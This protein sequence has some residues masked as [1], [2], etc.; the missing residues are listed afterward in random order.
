[1][2]K[3]WYENI[4]HICCCLYLTLNPKKTIISVSIF[5]LIMQTATLAN[6]TQAHSTL[7]ASSD[8]ATCKFQHYGPVC[9][10]HSCDSPAHTKTSAAD[11]DLRAL[12]SADPC[13]PHELVTGQTPNHP[14][15]SSHSLPATSTG[16]TSH[17]RL[18]IRR[19]L[20]HQP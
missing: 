2:Q 3:G 18:Y 10:M 9:D 12:S 6:P 4:Q 7:T 15:A 1:M 19:A 16:F 14:N 17:P 8:C 11:Y 20:G 5:V 13:P